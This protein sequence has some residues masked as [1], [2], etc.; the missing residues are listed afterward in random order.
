[1]N[2]CIQLINP[3]NVALAWV[4]EVFNIVEKTITGTNLGFLSWGGGGGVDFVVGDYGEDL[5]GSSS[6]WEEA[7]PALPPPCIKKKG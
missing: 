2:T 7:S 6:V 5:G 4:R 1:M 3:L